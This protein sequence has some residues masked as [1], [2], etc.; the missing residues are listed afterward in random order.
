MGAVWVY[1]NLG[2]GICSCECGG[3]CLWCFIVFRWR[4]FKCHMSV[5]VISTFHFLFPSF[6]LSI[7]YC[8]SIFIFLCIY[9]YFT[10]CL[11]PSSTVCH[12]LLSTV[13]LHLTLSF[14]IF[15]YLCAFPLTYLFISPSICL[16]LL[17]SII[18]ICR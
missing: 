2:C 6:S 1:M 17:Q 14:S 10:V 11:P 7:F 18:Y 4:L 3:G 13:Y 16:C 5:S 9:P 12:S 8:L 15:H